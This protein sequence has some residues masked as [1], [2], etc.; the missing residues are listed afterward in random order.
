MRGSTVAGYFIYLRELVRWMVAEGFNR[1]AELHASAL[2]KF[3]RSIAARPGLGRPALAPSTVQKYLHLFCYLYEFREELADTLTFDP[4]P[5]QSTGQVAGI[6][7]SLIRRWPATPDGVAIKLV[8]SA[9]RLI[10]GSSEILK[11]RQAYAMAFDRALQRGCG[12]D[13]C[14]NAARTGLRIAGCV[15]PGAAQPIERLRDLAEAIDMLYIACFVVISYLVGLRVSETLHLQAG[16]VQQR[17]SDNE[18]FSVLVGQIFKRQPEYA[19]RGHE[20]VAPPVAVMAVDV[21]ESLSEPHRLRTGRA[22]LWLRRARVSG[23]REWQVVCPGVI[24]IPSATRVSLNLTRFATWIG[25]PLHNGSPW[26]LST[27]QGRKTFARFVALRDR[28][29]LFALAQHL[30]HRERAVTD[31]GY[32]GSDYRLGEEIHAEVLEQSVGAWEH[33]LASP[34]LGG[35]AGVKIVASRPRFKGARVKQDIKAYARI[36]VEAGLTLGVCDWGFCVYREKTSACLG[37]ASGPNSA[38]REPS[39]CARCE[40][41]A[42]SQRHA[43]YWADQVHRCEELL[44]DDRIPLQTLRIVR[45]RLGEA[46]S[47]MSTI[48]KAPKDL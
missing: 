11:A 34:S 7:E 28:S 47:M 19:G 45:E 36:L 4:F 22:N 13:A 14:D 20:W 8:Q 42:V 43:S 27:H 23:A 1:F 25:L 40:N 39:T 18:N 24:S 46:R 3:R 15:L 2:S 38:R 44:N 9:I 41:F 32:A 21:L 33:M 16:C 48:M 30:G 29:A 37:N 31:H 17:T 5:G 12:A 6:R 35:R 26:K 10:E